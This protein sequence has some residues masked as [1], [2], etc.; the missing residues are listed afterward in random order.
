V[1]AAIVDLLTDAAARAQIMQH[2]ADV[3]PRYDWEITAADTMKVI[4]EAA[5]GR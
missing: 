5:V 2:A 3:L 4:E 1:A